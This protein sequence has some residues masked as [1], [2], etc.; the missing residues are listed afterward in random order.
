VLLW[1]EEQ[2][3]FV[4]ALIIFA[5]CYLLAVAMLIIGAVLSTHPIAGKV[6]ATTPAMLTPLG[7]ITGLLIAFLAARVWSTVDR[8][9][10]YVAQEASDIREAVLLS[11]SLPADLNAAIRNDIKEYLR[12]IDQDDWPAMLKGRASLK[13]RSP[14]LPKALTRLLSY[15]PQHAGQTV[16]QQDIAHAIEQALQARR[17]RILLSE[18]AISPPQW[19]AIILLDVLILLTIAMLHVGRHATTAIN[20]FIFSTAIAVC[21]VILMINDRPFTSGGNVVG[22]GPLHEVETDL[23]QPTVPLVTRRIGE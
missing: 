20:L 16:A 1:L 4:I 14:G 15:D 13:H 21:L 12:F 18:A 3:T 11:E 23:K 22:P 5:L 2:N 6:S 9:H 10:A 19:I 7:V 17:N 8:A